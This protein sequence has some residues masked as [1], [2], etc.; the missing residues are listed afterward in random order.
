MPCLRQ[1]TIGKLM[2]VTAIVATACA[3]RSV[4]RTAWEPIVYVL[5]RTLPEPF[6]PSWAS[7]MA[8]MIFVGPFLL[9]GLGFLLF[10]IRADPNTPGVK[11]PKPEFLEL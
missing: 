8:F 9:A 7:L 5:W 2:M 4:V 6:S 11:P 3:A 10:P 1:F